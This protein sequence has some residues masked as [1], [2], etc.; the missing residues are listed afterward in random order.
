[1]FGASEKNKPRLQGSAHTLISRQAEISG[2]VRFSGELIIEGTIRGNIFAEDESAALVRVAETGVVE[3]EICVPSAVINGLV[4]GDVHCAKHLELAAKA[5]VI[6]NV[7]YSLI[8]MVMGSEVN[9]SLMHIGRAQQDSKRLAGA[10]GNVLS[11]DTG[12]ETIVD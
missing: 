3:G 7:Y 4:R 11:Y 2:D 1:M 9:G 12:N 6:G 10:S 5:V 8:E